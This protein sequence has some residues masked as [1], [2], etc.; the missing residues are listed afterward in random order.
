[1][2]TVIERLV[3][4][5]FLSGTTDDDSLNSYQGFATGLCLSGEA[6]IF[7]IDAYGVTDSVEWHERAS[8]EKTMEEALSHSDDEKVLACLAWAGGFVLLRR[9][10]PDFQ[11]AEDLVEQLRQELETFAPTIVWARPI[12]EAAKVM[13]RFASATEIL[14]RLKYEATQ[15]TAVSILDAE[16]LTHLGAGFR[17][18][19]QA[20]GTEGKFLAVRGSFHAFGDESKLIRLDIR[21]EKRWGQDVAGFLNL[22]FPSGMPHLFAFDDGWVVR[23]VDENRHLSKVELRHLAVAVQTVLGGTI[24]DEAYYSLV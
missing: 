4:N 9:G 24:S 6:W 2:E 21:R 22:E 14:E 17:V 15:F 16:A 23:L 5:G 18:V 12:P 13:P 1:M 3:D 19:Q 8:L 20:E 11:L 7:V 10:K